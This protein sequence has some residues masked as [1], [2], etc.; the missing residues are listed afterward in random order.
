MRQILNQMRSGGIVSGSR[1]VRRSLRRSTIVWGSAIAL[2]TGTLAWGVGVPDADSTAAAAPTQTQTQTERY[3]GSK[4]SGPRWQHNN[5]WWGEKT[6]RWNKYSN[7]D[8]WDKYNNDGEDSNSGT[9][10]TVSPEPVETDTVTPPVVA[11]EPEPTPVEA[12]VSET[13]EAPVT[14]PETEAPV[15]TSGTPSAATT[16]VPS[17]VTLTTMNGLTV[18]TN[19]AVIDSKHVKGDIVINADNVTIKNSKVEG[20]IHIRPPFVGLKVQSTEIAG[21]GTAAAGATEAIGYANFSCDKC[22]IHGWGKGVMMDG[23]VSV[24]N[25]WIHDLAVGPDTHNEP[26]LSLGGS[27][28]N[29]VNNRLD[30]GTTGHFTAALSLLNQWNRLTDIL[31]KDNVFNGGGFCV[32]AGGEARHN[33]ARPSSNIRFIDNTFGTDLHSKCG[34]YGAATAWDANGAGNQWSGNAMSNGNA[35][36]APS[37]G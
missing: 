26:I 4:K 19:G 29:I 16:G 7:Q 8:R 24:T 11:P 5:A 9:P 3:D 20:R 37:A 23:N 28:Y 22:N 15:Q 31:V 27:N 13:P 25:S 14:E 35:V 12:P 34:F 10:D 6:D 17:G 32:Y 36:H 1:A 2:T 30:A 21:P 33:D 18:T